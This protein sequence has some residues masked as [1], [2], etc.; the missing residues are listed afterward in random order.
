MMFYEIGKLDQAE[1]LYNEI[2]T[3]NPSLSLNLGVI[4]NCVHIRG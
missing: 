4:M 2:I 3:L 1:K